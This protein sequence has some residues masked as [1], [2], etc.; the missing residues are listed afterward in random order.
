MHEMDKWIRS[1]ENRR[2]GGNGDKIGWTSSRYDLESKDWD[3]IRDMIIP[4]LIDERKGEPLTF[5]QACSALRNSWKAFKISKRRWGAHDAALSYRINR[6][7]YFLGIPLVQFEEGPP[8]SW[9]QEQFQLEEKS[10]EQLSEEEAQAK[11]EEDQEDKPTYDIWEVE[12]D[13]SDVG[14]LNEPED[15]LYKT[16]REEE[17][18]EQE[19]DWMDF[20]I[21]NED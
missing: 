3:S 2:I 1:Y 19:E 16:L 8:I 6:I 5:S 17:R 10:G 4:E 18:S 14:T 12:E 11:F 20:G 15:P 7:A 9:F 21:W 13:E